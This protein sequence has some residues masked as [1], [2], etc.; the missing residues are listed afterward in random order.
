MVFDK[1]K[2]PGFKPVKQILAFNILKQ[3]PVPSIS[4][5]LH[6]SGSS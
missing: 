3:I 5:L 6:S 2:R 4:F 1:L